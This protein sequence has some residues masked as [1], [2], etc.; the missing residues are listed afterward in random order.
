VNELLK[1]VAVSICDAND[2][3]RFINTSNVPQ[4]LIH[5]YKEAATE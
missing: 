1:Y 5:K 4:K 3:G 2:Q